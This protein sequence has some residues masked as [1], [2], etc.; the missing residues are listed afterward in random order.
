MAVFEISRALLVIPGT[1]P[2]LLRL[3]QGGG[4][5]MTYRGNLIRS[6][7]ERIKVV[8]IVLMTMAALSGCA[9]RVRPRGRLEFPMETMANGS[10]IRIK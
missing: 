2:L 3:P 7:T 5:E 4:R 6:Q 10:K 8:I 9:A 1:G